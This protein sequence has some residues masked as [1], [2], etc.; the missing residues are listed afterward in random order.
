MPS[1]IGVVDGVIIHVAE[2]VQAL[3]VGET[4]DE[5]IGGDEASHCGRVEA[6]AVVVQAT[7]TGL[8]A[9]AGEAA[10]GPLKSTVILSDRHATIRLCL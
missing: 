5:R 8:C 3:R 7:Q 6:R 2:A 10:V 1:W 9:L 4:G